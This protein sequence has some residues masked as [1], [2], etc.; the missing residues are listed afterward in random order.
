MMAPA[1]DIQ[2]YLLDKSNIEDTIQK[3]VLYYD[4]KDVSLLEQEVYAPEC[5]IDYTAMFGGEPWHTTSKDWAKEVV[6]LTGT[7]DS[8]QHYLS[9]ILVRLPQPGSNGNG[10]PETCTAIANGGAH[11]VRQEAEGGQLLHNGGRQD[12]EVVRL[13]ELEEQGENP[14]RIRTQK[15]T[16]LWTK[17]N[18][19]V[20]ELMNGGSIIPK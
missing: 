3:Q 4:L 1:Y 2:T 19:R 5:I 16:P 7:L 10:R 12:Y 17:G 15:I 6:E 14:W 9:G 13:P 18:P 8:A 11:M 20:L